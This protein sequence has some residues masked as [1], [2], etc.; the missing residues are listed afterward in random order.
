MSIYLLHPNK[1]GILVVPGNHTNWSMS[2]DSRNSTWDE[3]PCAT[4]TK[5]TQHIE[6]E[7]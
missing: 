1:R 3:L 6:V 7:V 2:G 5:T 4:E